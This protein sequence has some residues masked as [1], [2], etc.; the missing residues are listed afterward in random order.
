MKKIDWI[1]AEAEGDE[2][3]TQ[4]Q[5]AA[6]IGRSLD[7]VRNYIRRYPLNYPQPVA[8]IGSRMMYRRV[9]DIDAFVEWLETRERDRTPAE[10]AEGEVARIKL[11]LAATQ[12][13]VDRHTA[14]LEKAKRD[15]AHHRSALKKAEDL[16]ALYQV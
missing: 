14:S 13:R 12:T 15:L 4:G 11:V 16:L 3:E 5:T 10:V 9:K 1:V 7:T 8:R 6:R 2:I